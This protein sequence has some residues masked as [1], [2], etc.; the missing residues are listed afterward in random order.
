M[1]KIWDSR[2]SLGAI[3]NSRA[4]LEASFPVSYTAQYTPATH[5]RTYPRETTY[6]KACLQ[7]FIALVC[8][9]NSKTIQMSTSGG[10][11]EQLRN[12]E[13]RKLLT[14]TC[15]WW[16]CLWNSVAAKAARRETARVWPCIWN[17]FI[18]KF[19]REYTIGIPLKGLRTGCTLCIMEILQNWMQWQVGNCA[20]IGSH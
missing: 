5:L 7:N 2:K 10:T 12:S 14:H 20:Y 3:Q 11:H 16:K 4:T 18:R 6:K 17:F 1:Q 15:C 13:K 9:S 19:S 8:Q